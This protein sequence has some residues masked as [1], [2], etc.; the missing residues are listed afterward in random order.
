M[1]KYDPITVTTIL[2][3]SELVN[4]SNKGAFQT[5]QIIITGVSPSDAV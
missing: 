2:E 3:H 5:L 1:N 4:N